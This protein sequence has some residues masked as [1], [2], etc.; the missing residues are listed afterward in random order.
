MIYK[1]EKKNIARSKDLWPNYKG[2]RCAMKYALSAESEIWVNMDSPEDL[3]ELN[4]KLAAR[5]RWRRGAKN[6][7]KEY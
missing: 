1:T 7:E 4:Y 3:T 6:I 5:L 2:S